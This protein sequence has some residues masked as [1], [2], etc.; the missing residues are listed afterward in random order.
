[1]TGKN[2]RSYYRSMSN[3]EETASNRAFRSALSL[4]HLR[5]ISGICLHSPDDKQYCA[6]KR[7]GGFADL[8]KS[9]LH[10]GALRCAD[11]GHTGR[12]RSTEM[13]NYEM[14]LPIRRAETPPFRP[15][16]APDWLRTVLQST[17]GKS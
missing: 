5:A 10:V 8:S 2:D 11:E 9:A 7:Q 1:M 14:I 4:A 13:E 15:H 3:E 6:C 16:H 17:I 12:I